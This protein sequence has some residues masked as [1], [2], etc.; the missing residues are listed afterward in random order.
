[1]S[2]AIWSLNY[3]TKKNIIKFSIIVFL[4][5]LFHKSALFMFL[6]YFLIKFDTK[7]EY[8]FLIVLFL[9]ICF[10]KIGIDFLASNNDRYENYANASENSGGYLTII[11]YFLIG[12]IIYLYN[13]KTSIYQSIEYVLFEL[14]IL[15]LAFILPVAMLGSNPSGPQRLIF[16]SAWGLCLLIPTLLYKLNDKI[17]Y[18]LFINVKLE[19]SRLNFLALLYF[20][21]RTS[22]FSNLSP[23]QI[24]DIFRIF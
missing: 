2:I 9:S 21:M 11:F 20:N 15:G 18:L 1:M 13:K 22:S 14:Y 17:Y 23:Y 6:F 7:L 12:I 3:I 5:S 8:K 16:Y 4:A 19:S 10:S 24:N